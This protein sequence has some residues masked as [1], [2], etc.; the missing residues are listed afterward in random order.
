MSDPYK[1]LGVEP[2]ASDEQI[3]NAYRTLARKYHPDNYI[4]NPLAD[5]ATEKMKEINEAY[6]QIQKMRTGGASYGNTGSNGSYS[7]SSSSQF[8]DIRRL[9]N[10][11]RIVE[12]EELL[13]GVPPQNRDAEW[14]FLKGS[15][16]YTRGWLDDA[17]QHFHTACR[18]NP[19]NPE[20]RSALQQLQWQRQTGSYSGYDGPYRTSTSAGGCSCCDLCAA[21][22]CADCCCN[23]FGGGF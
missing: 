9:I 15:I 16:C 8:G 10:A 1:I 20:Y 23:C 5:L 14:Y 17:Y 6:D 21:M 7:S 18:M 12:A 3:K 19:Q 4:N 13:D 22:Y 2:N 11:K